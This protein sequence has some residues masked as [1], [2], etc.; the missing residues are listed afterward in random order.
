MAII[1]D[2]LKKLRKLEVLL[3]EYTEYIRVRESQP[4]AAQTVNLVVRWISENV[5]EEQS[6]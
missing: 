5:H 6:K 4:L 2:D 1:E 3:K